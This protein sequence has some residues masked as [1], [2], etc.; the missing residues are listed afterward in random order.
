LLLNS[1]GV[2]AHELYGA[3]DTQKAPTVIFNQHTFASPDL[4]ISFDY[5]DTVSQP[6][7]VQEVG[8]RVYLNARQDE[9]PLGKYVEVFSQNPSGSL[10]D[11]VK[12]QFLQGY[13]LD[14]CPVVPA[15]LNRTYMNPAHEYV[16]ITTPKIQVNNIG[17]E[18]AAVKLC[19]PIYTDSRAGIVYFMMD[20]SHPDKFVF[21]N[22]GQDNIF[23]KPT[24]SDVIVTWDQTLRF[25]H[26]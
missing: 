21:F 11:A 15:N 8:D 9:P 17:K 7:H 18:L 10:E 16:Q 25:I 3:T 19:P 23:G 24:T 22:L 5:A 1:L 12:K 4:D 6:I 14:K 20:H 26:I 13:S 2:S